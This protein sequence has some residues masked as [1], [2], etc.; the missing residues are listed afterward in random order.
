MKIECK[1]LK[2]SQE[3]DLS[4][5]KISRLAD[6]SYPAILRMAHNKTSS[7]DIFVLE[8]LCKVLNCKVSELIDSVPD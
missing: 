6:I 8:K 2:L 4:L 3:K 7:Y 5:S 1:L